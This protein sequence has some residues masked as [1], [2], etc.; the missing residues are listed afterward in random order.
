MLKKRSEEASKTVLRKSIEKRTNHNAQISAN[1]KC[2]S[3][4]D[5]PN[6]EILNAWSQRPTIQHYSVL[7]TAITRKPIHNHAQHNI[8]FP[9]GLFCFL[10]LV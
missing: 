10:F 6:Q 4:H 8:A 2:G 3:S 1:Q 7:C 9:W 5:F